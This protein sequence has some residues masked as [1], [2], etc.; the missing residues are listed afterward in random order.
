MVALKG[1]SDIG[2]QINKK[3]IRP[4]EDANRL[5]IKADFNDDALLGQGKEKVEKLTNLIGIFE[6]T[7][8]GFLQEPRRR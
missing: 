3:I 7:R 2:D 1:Q 8:P 5:K 6:S 4:L